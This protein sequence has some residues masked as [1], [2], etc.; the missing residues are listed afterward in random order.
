MQKNRDTLSVVD[1]HGKLFMEDVPIP[2]K[3]LS[4]KPLS[5]LASWKDDM[6]G[7][8]LILIE[9]VFMELLKSVPNLSFADYKSIE[10]ITNRDSADLQQ[11]FVRPYTRGQSTKN[12]I[13]CYL[14][15][16]FGEGHRAEIV[17]D[18]FVITKKDASNNAISVP[19]FRIVYICGKNG[20]LYHPERI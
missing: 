3:F 15:E 18:S 10:N 19:G 5:E 11:A 9:P 20:K 6:G 14:D 16:M 1:E 2:R 17:D 7:S 8:R 13:E 12:Q 4:L